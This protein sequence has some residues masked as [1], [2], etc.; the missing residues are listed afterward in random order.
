MFIPI[1]NIIPLIHKVFRPLRCRPGNSQ[2]NHLAVLCQRQAGKEGE[3]NKDKLTSTTAMTFSTLSRETEYATSSS[4]LWPCASRPTWRVS[5]TS[6]KSSPPWYIA[7]P[8]I[9]LASLRYTIPRSPTTSIVTRTPGYGHTIWAS[10]GP[11]R[12]LRAYFSRVIC[13]APGVA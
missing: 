4:S 9:P 13:R 10:K 12:C 8:W 6:S 11:L 1:H 2:V 5:S 7:M 3:G